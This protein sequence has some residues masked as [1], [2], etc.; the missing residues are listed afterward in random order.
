[1]PN[2]LHR[3]NLP[4]IVCDH[5]V[6]ENHSLWHRRIAGTVVMSVGVVIAQNAHHFWFLWWVV[7]CAGYLL[8]G[9]GAIPFVEPII[10]DKGGRHDG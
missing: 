9:I 2:I 1:M 8:H 10:K 4:R 3:I 6:G 7:D 5:L